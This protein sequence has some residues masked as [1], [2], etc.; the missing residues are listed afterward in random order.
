MRI[1]LHCCCA[2]CAVFPLKRLKEKGFEV[3]GF[4]Y[5]P[6]VHPFTEYR[7]RMEG[8]S[9]LE[10]VVDLPVIYEDSY[11]LEKYLKRV[12]DDLDKRCEHCYQLRLFRAAE[13]A[14]K[15]GFD[16]FTTTLLVSPYQDHSL[17]NQIGE[18]A[19]KEMGIEF[20]YEDFRPG[21][22]E[23]KNF[24]KEHNIYRQKYCG[25]VF[26]ERDRY[27]KKKKD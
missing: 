13:R 9:Y 17:I 16:R 23:G 11:E 4:W 18:R 3:T 14:K 15:E 19:G 8:L 27:Q 10:R 2:Q 7:N 5:N 12:M 26:S 22:Y 25:C 1:L 20:F 24:A 21:F 6:N